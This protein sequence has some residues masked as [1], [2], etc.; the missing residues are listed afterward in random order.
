MI[1]EKRWLNTK[2][3]AHEYDISIPTQE[4]Y[5]RAKMIPYTKIGG[6]IRYSRDK[7]E[8]WLEAHSFEATGAN[9]A[10]Y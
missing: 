5:R 4:R 9:H 6:F 10:Q 8:A 7:I 3:L 2:E 1:H